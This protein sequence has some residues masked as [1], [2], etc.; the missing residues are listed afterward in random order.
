MVVPVPCPGDVP[1]TPR[2]L[3]QGSS[4]DLAVSLRSLIG[5]ATP[6]AVT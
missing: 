4:G 2:V 6:P 5:V 1:I 3:D